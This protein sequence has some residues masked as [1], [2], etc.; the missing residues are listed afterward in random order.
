MTRKLG[1][2][3][4]NCNENV[5]WKNGEINEHHIHCIP[6]PF[7]SLASHLTI[8]PPVLFALDKLAV[9]FQSSSGG[10][11]SFRWIIQENHNNSIS[12]WK[13]KILFKGKIYITFHHSFHFI[14]LSSLSSH[15]LTLIKRKANEL[16]LVLHNDNQLNPKHQ[17][18][19][20]FD[21]CSPTVK[22]LRIASIFRIPSTS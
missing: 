21:F 22:T 17:R 12:Q 15:P 19:T 20:A 18:G 4:K 11:S 16:V 9:G 3:R 7:H 14:K 5:T 6:F 10:T 2:R 8:R 13:S 1:Q